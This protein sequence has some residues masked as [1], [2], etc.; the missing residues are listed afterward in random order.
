MKLLGIVA[1]FSCISLVAE[2][3]PTSESEFNSVIKPFFKEYCI[4]CHGSAKKP[5]ADYKIDDIDWRVTEGKD[6]IKWEKALE[7]ISLGDMPPEKKKQPSKMLRHKVQNWIAAELAKIGRGFDND[8][9]ALP[10]QANRVSHE[11]LFSGNH[12]SRNYSLSRL[13][14][15][16]PQIYDSLAKSVR[17]KLAQP[18]LGI[19][20]TGFQ[21]YASLLADEA[22]IK[23][24]LRN[25]YLV[26]DD[27]LSSKT[28]RHF[29]FLEAHE[30]SKTLPEKEKQQAIDLVFRLIFERNPNEEDQYYIKELYEKNAAVAGWREG[31]RSLFAGILLSPEYVFRME[32]GLGE[33]TA[34]GRHMLSP[35]ELAYAISFAFYDQPDK[36]LLELAEKGSLKTKQDVERE[37]RRILNSKDPK[38]N[39]FHYPM[40]H[41]WGEDYY[42]VNPRLLRFFQEFFGYTNVVNVFKDKSRFDQHHANRLRKDADF[43]VLRILEKDKD[44]IRELL[45][46]NRYST[47]PLDQNRIKNF[48]KRGKEDRHVQSMISKYPDFL[49]NLQAGK[50][51]GFESGH[52]EVYMPKSLSENILRSDETLTLPENQRA[53]MLTHPAWLVA[54]SLNDENDPVRRG[55]WIREHLLADLVPEVPIGVDAKDLKITAKL[56]VNALKLLTKKNAGAATKR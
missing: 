27:L 20:N 31:L 39:Y 3:K 55:K 44:V 17:M 50:F 30:N 38:N 40:Y 53:G 23:T 28:F 32:V 29:K 16:S 52:T 14:R 4:S 12:P 47:D 19:G 6:L 37:V 35:Q 43:F 41:R 11:E 13:W 21:D 54:F 48:L 26:A 22:T 5:K 56:F 42:S 45:T 51:Q 8:K 18:L 2:V 1:L 24:M 9:L 46:S 7:L 15:K 33:K 10:G 36:K 25:A 34:D 49:K